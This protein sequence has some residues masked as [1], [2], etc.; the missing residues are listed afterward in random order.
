MKFII[1][2]K[3][4]ETATR[5]KWIEVKIKQW[6]VKTINM[7][8]GP[9]ITFALLNNMNWIPWKNGTFKIGL[10]SLN[11]EKYKKLTALSF[12]FLE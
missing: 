5:N 10:V 9:M 1:F 2:G 12:L 7:S 3:I 8:W 6:R 4:Y 11:T